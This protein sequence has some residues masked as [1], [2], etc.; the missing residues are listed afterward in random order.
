MGYLS[1]TDDFDFNVIIR[2][3][4]I[5]GDQLFYPAGGAITSDSEPE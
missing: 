3:A 5:Q 1:P 4:I 2:T